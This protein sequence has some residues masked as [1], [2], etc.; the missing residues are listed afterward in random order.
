MVKGPGYD[1]RPR[2]SPQP[3]KKIF[4]LNLL[5]FYIKYHSS[6]RTSDLLYSKGTV[7]CTVF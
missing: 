3:N 5:L 6:A 7:Y 4:F 1:S 2:A